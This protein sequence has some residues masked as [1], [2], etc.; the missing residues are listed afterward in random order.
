MKQSID[1]GLEAVTNGGSDSNVEHGDHLTAFAEAIVGRDEAEIA[2]KRATMVEAAGE[3]SMVDA[4]GVA[5]NFQRMVRIADG[6]G[7]PLD[8]GL[9]GFSERTR[10]Q[11]DLNRWHTN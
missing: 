11:L 8:E 2:S 1:V 5:S 3:P 9:L 10:E 7:I 6:I 4:A